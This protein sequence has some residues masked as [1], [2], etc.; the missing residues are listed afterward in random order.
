[1]S[2][3]SFIGWIHTI[4]G[5]IALVLAAHIIIKDRVISA[6]VLV[7]K[8]YLLLT[9]A[10]AGTSLFIF[11]NG[12]FNIAHLLGVITL[13]AVLGGIFFENAG[14]LPFAKYLQAISYSGTILCSSIPAIS[15]VFT[16]L[17]ASNPLA[18]SIFDPI[19]ITSFTI[20]F[21]LFL[22]LLVFQISWLK[23]QKA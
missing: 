3:I 11:N 9:A 16:R 5:T 21:L 15:E 2:E 8:F 13:L 17:P 4:S 7:G 20:L 18:S 6:K 14:S 23:N 1:M 22:V 12:G 10:S 19:L